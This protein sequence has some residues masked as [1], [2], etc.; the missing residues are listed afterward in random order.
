MILGGGLRGFEHK[1]RRQPFV[2]ALD[3]QP[4][5]RRA[6]HAKGHWW[7]FRRW[8]RST[9]RFDCG[10]AEIDSRLARLDEP[11]RPCPARAGR[12]AAA[13]ARAHNQRDER[14][15]AADDH[16]AASQLSESMRARRRIKKSHRSTTANTE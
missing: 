2:G 12:T 1:R 13:Q 15:E 5:R 4:E 7:R 14:A 16:I 6:A 3:G 11:V 8:F 9:W 10:P